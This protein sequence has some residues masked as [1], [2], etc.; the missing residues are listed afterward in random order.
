MKYYSEELEELEKAEAAADKTEEALKEDVDREK[1]NLEMAR[2]RAK[3]LREEADAMVDEARE[4]YF[5]ALHKYNRKFGPLIETT[6]NNYEKSY[7]DFIEDLFSSLNFKLPLD[8]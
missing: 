2:E 8:K 3:E 7:K 5:E 4:K 1:N 6:V